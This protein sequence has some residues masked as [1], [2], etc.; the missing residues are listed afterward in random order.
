[1]VGGTAEE[2]WTADEYHQTDLDL[3][4]ALGPDGERALSE[5]GFKR[6]GR[7]WVHGDVNVAVEFP[8]SAIDG[9]VDRTVL[10]KVDIGAARI[11]GVDDLYLDRLRQ[12]T[13]AEKQEGIEFHSALA[14]AV[15]C[16]EQIDWSYVIKRIAT[17]V[18]TDALIGRSM[19]QIDSKIRRRVRR[20]TEE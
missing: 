3:C 16:F 18:K 14:V 10:A 2:Y 11:I 4:V 7:H 20:I 19:R 15:A 5:V 17:T 13:V 9:D 6:D 12:A 1:M 8:E